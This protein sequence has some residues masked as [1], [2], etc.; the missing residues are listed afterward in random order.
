MN[1]AQRRR[2]AKVDRRY[3]EAGRLKGAYAQM[4]DPAA[5][6]AAESLAK[7]MLEREAAAEGPRLSDG[8]VQRARQGPITPAPPDPAEG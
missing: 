5:H 7:S 6:E 4:D 1:R 3:R 8:Y 2:L